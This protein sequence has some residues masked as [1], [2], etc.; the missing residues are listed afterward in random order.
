MES[1]LCHS[2][3][4]LE[5]LSWPSWPR[6]KLL[7][8]FGP[9][10]CVRLRA[11]SWPD[12][13]PGPKGLW[14]RQDSLCVT[15]ERTPPVTSLYVTWIGTGLWLHPLRTTVT[16]QPSCRT[17]P[18]CG[19]TSQGTSRTLDLEVVLLICHRS[20]FTQQYSVFVRNI[21]FPF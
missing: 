3:L 21:T 19:R 11:Y 10:L 2:P 13:T 6:P 15:W 5:L 9:P 18:T 7:L 17:S 14:G 16:P 1:E 8:T 4:Q 20:N 12:R